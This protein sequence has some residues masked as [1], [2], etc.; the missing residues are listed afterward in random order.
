[1]KQLD[2]IA[3]IQI[4]YSSKTK[5]A[6]RIKVSSSQDVVNALRQ[7]WP[8]YEH[9]EYSYLVLM[10]RQNQILGF[11]QLS[12]GGTTGTVIDPKVVFQVALKGNANNILLAHNHPSGN[13]QPS[14]ADKRLT[15]QVKSGGTF[16]EIPL[17]DHIILTQE[18]YLSFADEG[19]L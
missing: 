11:H 16:L 8:S 18:S 5:S 9:V 1:M 13:T 6:D 2:Q 15:Q 7:F 4:S 17:L 19:Y 14:D 12:K 10:N 3:E